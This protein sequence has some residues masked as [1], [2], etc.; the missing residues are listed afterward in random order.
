MIYSIYVHILCVRTRVHKLERFL[1]VFFCCRCCSLLGCLKLYK[2]SSA[3]LLSL[4]LFC[5]CT[6]TVVLVYAL[7][8]YTTILYNATIHS[9]ADGIHNKRR[10][11]ERYIYTHNIKLVGVMYTDIIIT[12]LYT[13]RNVYVILQRLKT[14]GGICAPLSWLQPIV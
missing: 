6:T 1:E 9:Y 12:T 10:N 14:R 7:H 2:S 11:G 13:S 4:P 3:C 8:H 5:D